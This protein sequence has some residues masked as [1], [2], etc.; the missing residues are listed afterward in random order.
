MGGRQG[1][2]ADRH[3]F[4]TISARFVTISADSCRDR[5]ER[6]PT[7]ER[8]LPLA[9]RGRY[10]WCV[11]DER[12]ALMQHI[13]RLPRRLVISATA[14]VV[15]ASGA[16]AYSAVGAS[17]DDASTIQ[18][19]RNRASGLVRIVSDPARCT[20]RESAISW[21]VQG[22]RGPVGPAGPMGPAGPT[23][24]ST[25]T[26]GPAGPQGTGGARGCAR[27]SRCA[28]ACRCAGACRRDRP[29]GARRRDRPAGARR[30]DGAEG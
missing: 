27:A 21:N 17:R 15:A 26:Q 25:G 2:Q 30:S 3:P 23:G 10:P 11:P 16:A 14:L 9:G 28:R 4:A 12:S 13:S 19:C 8:T 6:E 5:A 20:K 22:P 24:T 7:R 29:A 18:A 1:S